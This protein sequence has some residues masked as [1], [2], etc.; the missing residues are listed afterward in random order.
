MSDDLRRSLIADL[1]ASPAT[2]AEASILKKSGKKKFSN[3][4]R[5]K[6]T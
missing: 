1:L 4:A 2:A 3:K 6:Y 5:Q